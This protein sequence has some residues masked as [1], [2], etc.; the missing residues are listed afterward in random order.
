MKQEI[1]Q[2]FSENSELLVQLNC[3]SLLD[4]KKESF[5]LISSLHKKKHIKIW[6]NLELQTYKHISVTK[7]NVNKIIEQCN[8]NSKT[9]LGKNWLF[10]YFVMCSHWNSLRYKFENWSSI[11]NNYIPLSRLGS[12]D[13]YLTMEI[14]KIENFS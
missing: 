11:D 4:R 9:F 10:K 12:I 8:S 14:L 3:R 13:S 1:R 2:A 6:K 7:F 5:C